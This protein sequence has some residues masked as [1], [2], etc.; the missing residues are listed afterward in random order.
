MIERSLGSHMEAKYRK[1]AFSLIQL[2]VKT[3][4]K[5]QSLGHCNIEAIRMRREL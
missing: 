3:S 1:Q 5:Q 2:I 4:I